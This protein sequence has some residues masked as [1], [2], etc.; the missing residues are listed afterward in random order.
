MRRRSAKHASDIA[1][2]DTLRARRWQLSNGLTVLTLND[3][4]VPVVAYHTWFRVGSRDD[5]AGKTGL[6]HFFEHLMFNETENLPHGEFD[7][8]MEEAG[9]DTNAGTWID[10]TYYHQ[11]LPADELAL[12]IE[13]EAER[14]DRLV[15]RAP[16]VKSEREVVASER[17]SDVEDD[18]YGAADERLHVLAFGAEH[19]HGWPT[20]GW[21]KDIEGFRVPD[22]RRF[23][24]TWY[25][26]NNAT[27][28]IAG[29]VDEADALARIE[30]AYGGM[31]ASKLPGRAKVAAPRRR[32][33]RVEELPWP[34]HSEKLAVA[35]PAPP[36]ATFEH[37][38]AEVV[39]DL[40]LGGRSARLWR[41][42][43]EELEIV[44]RLRG[45][46]GG[47]EHEGLFHLWVS[48]REGRRGEEAL[49]V[50][51]EEVQ[52]LCTEPVSEAELDKVKAR[53]E[54]H[55]LGDIETAD[56]KAYALG[57]G[58]TLC[59]DPAHQLVR[60]DELRRVSPDDVRRF[61]QRRL[62]P[63]RRSRVH[64]RVGER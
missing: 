46:V 39:Y 31:K 13:L 44:S 9:A 42:L 53:S 2:G 60:L 55:S 10:W 20:L 5:P 27:I 56:G 26:P 61:A 8:R 37:A 43:V 49:Q 59:R 21:M 29:N 16:Q 64:V 51:D 28:V 19:P 45:T 30:A 38:V 3:P 18:V 33:E 63:A 4:S 47:L 48:M 15:L 25:A 6:A 41:R 52:R 7:R 36:Y 50:I 40:W 32:R 14:M 54:L 58:E 22:C 57:Y 34:T 23:Y 62:G 35:W 12:A 17:R 1:F 24:R 11:T